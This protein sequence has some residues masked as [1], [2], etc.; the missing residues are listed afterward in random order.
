MMEVVTTGAIRHA[1]LQSNC[2]HQHTNTQLLTG[3]MPFLLPNQQCPSTD[4][5]LSPHS[6]KIIFSDNMDIRT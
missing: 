1:E 2:H 6:W 4:G 3:Q 5:K